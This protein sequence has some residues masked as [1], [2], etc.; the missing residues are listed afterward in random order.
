MINCERIDQALIEYDPDVKEARV[1]K[2]EDQRV[3]LLARFPK[4]GWSEMTLD[5]YALGQPNHPDN[6]C[7]WMEFVTTD[8]GSIKGGS[9]RKHLI[10]YQAEAGRWWFN[11]KLYRDVEEAWNA[12]HTGFLKA[13][14][15]AEAGEWDE[16]EQI[17]ALRS[18]PALLNKTLWA[19]FPDALMPI[20]S[21]SHLR[22]YLRELGDPQ[23]DDQSLSTTRLSRRLLEGL[24]ACDPVRGWTTQQLASLLYSAVGAPQND[25]DVLR[26]LLFKWATDFEPRTVELHREIAT[27]EGSV[28]WGKFGKPGSTSLS[29]KRL[30]DIRAQLDAG[31]E[32]HAY[33]YR[34][35]ELWRTRLEEITADP[36]DVD[37]ERLPSY[38]TKDQCVLFARV[39]AFEQ[40]DPNWAVQHLVLSSKP[41]PERMP[42]ALGNQTSPLIV[43]ELEASAGIAPSSSALDFAWLREHTLWDEADLRDLEETIRS[44]SQVILAG[45]PGTGKTWVAKHLVRYMTQ[46]RPL[47]YNLVQFHPS[48]GYEDFIEGL[49]P[50][51]I[52]GGIQFDRVDGMVLEVVGRM[53]EGDDLSF[54]VMDEM[55][56][57]NLP[58]VLGE[59]MYLLEYRGEEESINLQYSRDFSLPSNLR[60]IGT[61]NTADRSI[62]SIDTALRRRFEIFECPPDARILERYHSTRENQ[63]DGLIEGFE[64]LN[65]RLSTELDRHHTI[66]HTFFMKTPMSAI[67]LDRVWKRQIQPLIEEYF[68]DQPNT[69][70][71]FALQEFWPNATV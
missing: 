24:R 29:P 8:M 32:T 65:E 1:A 19:Y 26:H 27:R 48:Y 7:R 45:P 63:I 34:S 59:L 17:A 22:H 54:I 35:G 62:R 41:E 38:Y 52:D 13:I 3:Q 37:E 4:D 49:R 28:W 21:Q 64:S 53:E 6:F 60:F 31:T 51:V 11:E 58:R 61:M 70:Q 43:L 25:E 36:D 39:S 71:A 42:G 50:V 5:R 55:N 40:L 30:K 9:A 2:A 10:Y 46:D 57:A 14:E 56:R 15:Y 18:A 20:N 16:I 44:G 47:A 69:A 68:F 66:G 33:I 12:V 67:A 23:A